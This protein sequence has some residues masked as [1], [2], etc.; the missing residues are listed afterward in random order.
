[1][2]SIYKVQKTI[3]FVFGVNSTCGPVKIYVSR[4]KKNYENQPS[5]VI[6]KNEAI[7]IIN[8]RFKENTDI[9]KEH[10]RRYTCR[11]CGYWSQNHK[12]FKFFEMHP[13]QNRKISKL[14]RTTTPER[15]KMELDRRYM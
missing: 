3:S 11:R 1:V 7:E 13:P 9:I 10:K 14:A 2:A 4:I 12:N 8:N 5:S 15:L 6:C